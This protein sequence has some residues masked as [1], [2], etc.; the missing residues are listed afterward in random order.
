ML[1]FILIV[2]PG[3]AWTQ[4]A[5]KQE[6]RNEGFYRGYLYPV[7]GL[8]ALFSFAGTLFSL[9]KFDVQIALKIVIKQIA[10]FFGSFYLASLVL[11]EWV[12]PRF[13]RE[14]DLLVCERFTGYS[15]ALIYTIAMLESLFPSLFFLSLIVFYSV[16]MV[17]EGIVSYLKA[18]ENDWVKFTVWSSIVILVCPV[19]LN[20]LIEWLMPG[21][22]IE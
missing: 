1:L 17:W 19:V 21:L 9:G 15:S 18:D 4:L 11:S 6:N 22:K 14:K 12:F 16:Y 10:V 8:I 5:E 7:I 3:K 20:F 2:D 13:G